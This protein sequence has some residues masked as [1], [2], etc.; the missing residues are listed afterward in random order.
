[1]KRRRLVCLPA[2]LCLIAV[3]ISGCFELR[4]TD[5]QAM[6]TASESQHTIPF[7]ASF[8]ATLSYNP[9]G[10]IVSYLWTFGDGGTDSGPVVDHV[11]EQ[12]GV[13]E[14]V[15][16]IFDSEGKTATTRT[17][18]EALNPLPTAEFTY[19]PRSTMENQP[20][21]SASEEITFDGAESFDDEEVVSYEW[22]FGDTQ[23]ATGQVVKHEYLYPG[24]YNVV[25][26]V[27]DNDGGTMQ[28]VQQV[29]VIGGTPCNAD[30]TGDIPWS[31]Q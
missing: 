1:M 18:I 6:F 2:L 16:T 11:Y 23:T 19:T 26:T 27:T 31:C 28:C 12:N 25:L 15:L 29:C 13:Y 17:H 3:S 4:L 14:V 24:T 10:E 8:D 7:T 5:P 20:V 9:E 21:V 30:I 22:Y